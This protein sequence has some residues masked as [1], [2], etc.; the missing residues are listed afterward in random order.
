MYEEE[1]KEIV[2]LYIQESRVCMQTAN[3]S[4]VAQQY[5]AKKEKFAKISQHDRKIV[6]EIMAKDQNVFKYKNEI[7]NMKL[8]MELEQ[9]ADFTHQFM[10]IFIRRFVND[11]LVK[12]V[13]IS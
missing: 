9:E 6:C 11:V 8:L 3:Q 10:Q 1:M 13:P 5:F 12:Y 7:N 2:A 4:R